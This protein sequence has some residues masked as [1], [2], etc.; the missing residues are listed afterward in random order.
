[1]HCGYFTLIK[2]MK[3]KIKVNFEQY[4]LHSAWEMKLIS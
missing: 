1:M 4:T 2:Y 3:K